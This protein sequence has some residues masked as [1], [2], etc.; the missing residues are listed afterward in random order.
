MIKKN[1]YDRRVYESV[2]ENSL[3]KAISQK[4]DEKNKSCN[5]GL[6]LDADPRR[7]DDASPMS[8][9]RCLLKPT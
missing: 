8:S 7:D 4:T 9:Y 5:K 3:S 1:F 2:D 6:K